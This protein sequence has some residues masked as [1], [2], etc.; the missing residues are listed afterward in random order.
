MHPP[1][2]ECTSGESP[3]SPLTGLGLAGGA[4]PGAGAPGYTPTPLPGLRT[5]PSRFPGLA[6]RGWQTRATRLRPYRG[7]GRGPAFPGLAP[8]ATRLRP[9]RGFGRGVAGSAPYGRSPYFPST[10]AAIAKDFSAFFIS[11]RTR[12]SC[13]ERHRLDTPRKP[14]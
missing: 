13:P 7:F 6:R 12:L 3:P 14:R 5:R 9:Y 1:T 2:A 4:I 10:R 11:S 8:R